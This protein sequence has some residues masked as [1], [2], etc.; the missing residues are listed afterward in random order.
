MSPAPVNGRH[1]LTGIEAA[2]AF[3]VEYRFAHAQKGNRHLVVVFANFS[4]PGDY[5]WSNGVFDKL[6]ANI[7]WIRDNF[8]GKQSYYLCRGMDFGLEQSVVTLIS[9]VM[10]S[11]DL[12][13][14]S[15]TLWGG[16]KGGSAALYF[17]LKYGFKNIVAIAPQFS[18]GTYVKNVHPGTAR[19]MLGE[20]VPEENVR[21][22]DSLVPDLARSGANR[23][24]NIYL[25]SSPQDDQYPTQVEP[26]LGLF[27][28]YENFNFVFS[29]SPHIADH[30]QIAGRNVP[31][32]MGIVNLL[33][34]GIAPRLGFVSNGFE[35]PNRDRSAIDSYLA[36]TS[37][38]RGDEFLPPAVTAPGP[39][40]ELRRDAVRLTGHAPGAVRVVVWE[41]GKYLG[42]T[43]VDA[44]GA[45]SWE[46]GRAWSK[47]EHP[48]KVYGVDASGFQSRRTEVR[49]TAVDSGAAAVAQPME[50]ASVISTAG[51]S[52][53][54]PVVLEPVA[55]EQVMD[56]RVVFAGSAAASTQ[57]GFRENGVLLGGTAVALNGSWSWEAG[58]QW[59]AGAHVIDV[60]AVDASGTESPA[61]RVPFTVMQTSTGAT[62]ASYYGGTY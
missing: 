1:L 45:W 25:V 21:I 54:A 43:D 50:R 41:H 16:S 17:G 6:R 28:H 46:L 31:M 40:A 24:A 11:L 22:V 20:G 44:H 10:K 7:L 23:A 14:E 3:P 34:D 59:A 2:G 32:L 62:P 52:T 4:A 55:H 29:D 9:N 5:G 57:V 30:T 38:V 19:F 53:T 15:V 12:T 37:R 36:A 49:F 60:F 61:T 8:E 56:S 18:I 35:E 27:Q 39:G 33:I 51:P 42:Q 26:F 58:W 13:T 47:G 48:V